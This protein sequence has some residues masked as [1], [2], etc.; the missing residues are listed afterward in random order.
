MYHIFSIKHFLKFIFL[1]TEEDASSFSV[2]HV[3]SEFIHI[4]GRIHFNNFL[5]LK[6]ITKHINIKKYKFNVYKYIQN[7]TVKLHIVIYMFIK[8]IVFFYGSGW[9]LIKIFFYLNVSYLFST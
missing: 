1:K 5:L 9:L 7:C 3:F 2:F 8:T 4:N 6:M